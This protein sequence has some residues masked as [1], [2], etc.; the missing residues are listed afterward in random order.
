MTNITN[1][2]SR[3][4]LLII[5]KNR[6]SR[7]CTDHQEVSSWWPV[8]INHQERFPLDDPYVS[9]IKRLAFD[10][11]YKPVIKRKPLLM[12]GT[13]WSSRGNLFWW[14]I[15]IDHL[16]VSSWWL[17]QPVHQGKPLED[18]HKW[19]IKRKLH[20]SSRGSLLMTGQYQTLL[21]PQLCS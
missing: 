16:R 19:V 13:D 20:W 7:A 2:S 17:V 4:F 14:P 11:W 10:D 5:G 1:G 9:V 21:H 3:E 18:Q 12:I 8:S 6:S 15:G